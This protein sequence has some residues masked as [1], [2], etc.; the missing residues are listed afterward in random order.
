MHILVYYIH[1]D[2]TRFK[3]RVLQPCPKGS[4]LV[5]R[6]SHRISHPDLIVKVQVIMEVVTNR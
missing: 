5:R 6:D 3:E 4:E 2:F 1:V